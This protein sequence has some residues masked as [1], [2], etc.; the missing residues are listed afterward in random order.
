MD[1]ARA[2]DCLNLADLEE[3][4]V[5][6]LLEAEDSVPC[7]KQEPEL[8]QVQAQ[9]QALELVLVSKKEVGY[10]EKAMADCKQLPKQ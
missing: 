1:E 9:A 5:R 4:Q 2:E 10:T 3:M 6:L 8:G 7:L